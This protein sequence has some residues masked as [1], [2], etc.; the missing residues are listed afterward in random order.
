MIMSKSNDVSTP[1]H[2]TSVHELTEGDLDAVSGGVSIIKW[3]T[4]LL[5]FKPVPDKPSPSVT[6]NG[7][8]LGF[9]N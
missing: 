2:G 7:G 9:A 6:V 5:G 3:V 4:E 1:D 8:P